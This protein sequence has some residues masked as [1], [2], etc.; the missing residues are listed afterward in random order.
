MRAKGSRVSK[1]ACSADARTIR[2]L[3]KRT[4]IGMQPEGIAGVFHGA[5]PDREAVYLKQRKGFVKV[6]IQAGTGTL[7]YTTSHEAMPP[8]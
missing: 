6:A 5:R 3:L 7:Q 2:Q 4:S 1:G 8:D